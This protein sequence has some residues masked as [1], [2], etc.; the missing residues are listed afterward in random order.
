MI[1]I[2]MVSFFATRRGRA[3]AASALAARASRANHPGSDARVKPAA[4]LARKSLRDIS[5]EL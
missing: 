1:A 2:W 3:A 5:S 4:V